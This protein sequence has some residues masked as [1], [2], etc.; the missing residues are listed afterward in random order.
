[1]DSDNPSGADNQQERPSSTDWLD[2]IQC[3]LGNWVAGFVDGEG[4]FNV[5]IRR[6][7]D[8]GLPWR[9]SLSFNVSQIGAEAPGLLREIFGT[10][11]VRG[12]GDGVFY[13]E[14][15]KPTDLKDRVFPFFDR[16][17][18]RSPK[19]NDLAVFRTVTELVLS[20]RHLSASG[21]EEALSLRGPMNRGGKRR[22]SD[23]T[24]IAAF[25]EWESSEAICRAPSMK[26]RD[27]D[28]VHT[29]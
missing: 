10:G 20:G 14:V 12:R 22:R 13:F 7:R 19:R 2:R 4:S 3:D 5:P 9:V 1:M 16:F 17:Q 28:M 24:I 26:Q 15:T 29:S 11:T 23:A 6:E 27:E 8:R 18:L 21:I 25:R